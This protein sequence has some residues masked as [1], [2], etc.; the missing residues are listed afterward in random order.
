MTNRSQGLF[1]ASVV[2]GCLNKGSQSASLLKNLYF[3]AWC[4]S[5]YI[6]N[7]QQFFATQVA[8]KKWRVTWSCAARANIFATEIAQEEATCTNNES[9]V[10][11]ITQGQDVL[12]ETHL[13]RT[14]DHTPKVCYVTHHVVFYTQLSNNTPFPITHT[15]TH[16]Y[17][18]IYIYKLQWSDS[19][20][21]N[22]Q[23]NDNN[24]L[25]FN[26]LFIWFV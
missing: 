14:F 20:N 11:L 22:R 26:F 15:H 13:T 23:W 24:Y 10:C 21:I 19:Y 18:Y 9:L 16:I 12:W 1:A 17:I 6:Y 25:S 5:R 2:R 3:N 4:C 8:R 7:S